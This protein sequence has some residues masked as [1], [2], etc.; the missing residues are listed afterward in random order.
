[1]L[2]ILW[3]QYLK[4]YPE[5]DFFSSYKIYCVDTEVGKNRL[6]VHMVNNRRINSCTQNCEPTFAHPCI[7][8][9]FL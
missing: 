8:N 2:N 7:F 4:N 3:K 5:V 1:M 9:S 6:I